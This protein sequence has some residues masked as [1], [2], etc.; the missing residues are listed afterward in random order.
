M[1]FP[2]NFQ[3]RQLSAISFFLSAVCWYTLINDILISAPGDIYSEQKTALCV[4]ST[5]FT[6]T[7]GLPV[8]PFLITPTKNKLCFQ[9]LCNVMKKVDTRTKDRQCM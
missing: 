5:H 6:L 8:K 2:L 7:K 3:D 9:P 1:F 4:F